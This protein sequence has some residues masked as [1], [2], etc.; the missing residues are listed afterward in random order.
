MERLPPAQTH[1]A[2]KPLVPLKLEFTNPEVDPPSLFE[3]MMGFVSSVCS[4][5]GK[6]LKK[7]KEQLK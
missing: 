6:S 4:K 1:Y 3:R 5:I 7:A 2:L